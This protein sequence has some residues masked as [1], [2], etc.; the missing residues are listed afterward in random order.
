MANLLQLIER[1]ALIGLGLFSLHR[2]WLLVLWWRYRDDRP[3]AAERF[4]ELPAV[5]VQ[6][7]VYNEPFVV[8]RLLA[9]VALRRR[10]K[11][12]EWSW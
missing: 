8:E 1:I 11:A 6:L 4:R 7:P 3:S 9:A 5:T 10:D 2:L 12:Y